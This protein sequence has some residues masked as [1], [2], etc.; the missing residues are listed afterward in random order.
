MRLQEYCPGRPLISKEDLIASDDRPLPLKKAWR[1]VGVVLRCVVCMCVRE[2]VSACG[3]SA[4]R[5]SDQA[6]DRQ[7]AARLPAHHHTEITDSF[8]AVPRHA[9]LSGVFAF[10]QGSSWSHHKQE[11][12]C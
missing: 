6:I 10:Q 3:L 5:H 8:L 2:C 1:V 4:T 12:N 7:P 11:L 9:Q